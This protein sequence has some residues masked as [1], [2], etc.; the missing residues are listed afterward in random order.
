M[1]QKAILLVLAV[2][3]LMACGK[4]KSDSAAAAVDPNAPKIDS[5]FVLNEVI[6]IGR[7][8]PADKMT[9]INADVAGFVREVKYAENQLIKK[10]QVLL[11]LD[12]DVE[13]SQLTQSKSKIAAQQS[14]ISSANANLEV[15]KVKIVQ[16]KNT[17]QRNEKLVAGNAG[18]QQSVDD[19]RFLVADLEKQL[20]QAA[21][22]VTQAE[23]KL[24]ELKAD[25]GYFD[26]LSNRKTIYAPRNGRFLSQDVKPGQYI[27]T[28]T[29]LGDFAPEGPTQVICEIDE[30]YAQ[31]IIVGQIA[32]IRLQGTT[33]V[34]AAG[35]V[36]YTA[37]Y[38][39]KKSLFS[40]R[41][42]NLEDRRI[43]EVRIQLDD[44]SKVIL[45]QRVEVLIK[46]K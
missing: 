5:N 16:A 43:R 12:N 25:I 39:K 34:I 14:A 38:L 22:S 17:L 3:M 30:L 37:P 21:V 45:G 41:A 35:K 13:Q 44:A 8:E 33:E 28:S 7:V 23:H 4:E 15:Y 46:L 24:A 18:T 2:S 9:T 36:Q 29:S 11:V 19:A 10:G 42:D 26:V 6:G 1:F 20:A 32:Q 27:S 40:D 31:D